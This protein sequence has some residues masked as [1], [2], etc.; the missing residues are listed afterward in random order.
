MPW[1]LEDEALDKQS[2]LPHRL[3]PR[4]GLAHHSA[5]RHA[6]GVHY[7]IGRMLMIGR[8]M[9]NTI[10]S[11]AQ[12]SDLQLDCPDLCKPHQLSGGPGIIISALMP[13]DLTDNETTSQV[14]KME[15]R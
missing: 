12:A 5:Q 8:H 4:Q 11:V 10:W 7:A 1:S 13:L 15:M 9:W 3:H 14:T 2:W 6:Y